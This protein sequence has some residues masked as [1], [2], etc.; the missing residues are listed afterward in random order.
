M[1][2]QDIQY[3]TQAVLF[4]E[5]GIGKTSPNPAVGAV[6]VQNGKIIGK[7]Y[8]KK[9]GTAHAEILAIRNALSHGFDPKGATLYVTLEPCCHFGKTPPCTDALLKYGIKDVVMGSVDPFPKVHGKGR[10]AL[11]RGGVSV[12]VLSKQSPLFQDIL[13]LNQQYLKWADTG[14]PYVTLK[15]G[16]SLDGKIATRAGESK[17]I[18]SEKARTDAR[19]ERSR[20]DA[21]LIGAGTVRSDDPVLAAHG[22][23]KK[24]DMLRVILDPRLSLPT[25]HHVFR[26]EHVFVATT[27][28]ASEKDKER[29]EKAGIVFKSF[30]PTRISL[31]RL[32]QY[33]GKE[34]IQ[35]VFVEGGSGTHGYFVDDVRLDSLM[36]DRVLFYVE[37]ILLGGDGAVPVVGGHGRKYVKNAVHLSQTSVQDIGGTLKITGYV[38]R[39]D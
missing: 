36:I 18:T 12:S 20:A 22:A 4:A 35:H 33:L 1:T 17:W 26:D 19:L 31:K 2:E 16:M 3:M 13:S 6:L 30:G 39:Y 14:L 9:A 5:K 11:Q 10:D 25:T 32:L 8:H 29:F 34:D 28:R 27:N 24:K 15:A 37:P 21:V 38:N 7:G 23:Y